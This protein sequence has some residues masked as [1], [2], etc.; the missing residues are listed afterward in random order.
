MVAHPD[1]AVAGGRVGGEVVFGDIGGETGGEGGR[2]EFA[3]GGVGFG[4]GGGEG[5]DGG[6][7][8]GGVLVES[9]MGCIYMG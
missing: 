4:G 7:G 9:L 3:V 6:D 1:L 2:A 5:E 8:H